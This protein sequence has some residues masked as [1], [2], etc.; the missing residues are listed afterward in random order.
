MFFPFHV[1]V[2]FVWTVAT[3]IVSRAHMHYHAI[4]MELQTD[5][6]GGERD[7]TCVRLATRIRDMLRD[8]HQASA[9]QY[10]GFLSSMS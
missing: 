2:D 4:D 9:A 6:T 1:N 8:A 5:P 3:A 10:G 7:S